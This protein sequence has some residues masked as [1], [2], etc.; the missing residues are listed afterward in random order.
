MLNEIETPE[1]LNN[2]GVIQVELK[3]MPEALLSFQAAL[4]SV[5][6]ILKL[7][8]DS[9]KFKALNI[10]IKFNLA[11]HHEQTNNLAE[12]VELY[13]D[14]LKEEPLYIDIYYRK[15]G[16]AKKRGDYM[17]AVEYL[18]KAKK[19]P[20]NRAPV[21]QMLTLALL[22][23]EMGDTQKAGEEFIAVQKIAGLKEPYANLGIANL[24]YERSTQ[25]RH[26]EKKQEEKMRR[27]MKMYMETLEL[28][29]S[30]A[31]ATLGLANIM[32]EHG[33]IQDAVKIYSVLKDT[34]PGCS[35][36]YVNLAIMHAS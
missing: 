26:E 27:A 4:S 31:F 13:N 6:K 14:I 10:T 35:H 34:L 17:K 32:A 22:Y 16:I 33:K 15:A 21:N 29:P 23:Q 19:T 8:P 3:K 18:E 5:N 12:A 1:I 25:V 30:N 9:K 11:Y 28:D 36:S 20:S 7:T 24:D 2:I